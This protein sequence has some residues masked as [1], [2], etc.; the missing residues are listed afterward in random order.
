MKP[1]QR[2]IDRMLA[3]GQVGVL[4]SIISLGAALAVK[5][6]TCAPLLGVQTSEGQPMQPEFEAAVKRAHAAAVEEMRHDSVEQLEASIA[7]FS[8]HLRQAG[9][10]W[11]VGRSDN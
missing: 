6:G 7:L 9:Y 8:E 10:V 5:R 1:P 3:D 11:D 2:L 4:S